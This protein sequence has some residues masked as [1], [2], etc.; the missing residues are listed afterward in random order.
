MIVFGCPITDY[1]VYERYAEPGIKL[2]AEPDTEVLGYPN[3]GSIFRAYNL[4]CKQAAELEN[5]EALVL[6]HQDVEIVDP[7][8][9]AKVRDVFRD[10]EV[11][12]AGCTGAVGVR[13]LAWW[14]GS[15]TWG[16]YN[17]V[18]DEIG[19]DLPGLSWP[20]E[21][22]FYARTGE[23]DSIDG[24]LIALSPWAVR[25]LRFDENLG[26]LHGYDL[27]ISLQARAAGKKV[28]AFDGRVVHHHGVD[29]I[30]DWEGWIAAHM[31]LAEKWS[32][33]LE[34]G[35]SQDW[36]ARARRAE[37]EVDA[38]WMQLRYAREHVRRLAADVDGFQESRSWRLTAPLRAIGKLLRRIRHPRTSPGRQLGEGLMK[39]RAELPRGDKPVETPHKA[40]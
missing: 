21:R 24:V 17:Q 11:A 6:I 36:R 37:A 19:A 13:S 18:F 40:A 29:L 10:P 23:V 16:S 38:A 35:R 3:P 9:C 30:G 39:P 33:L 14:E 8:L 34:D 5:L 27:D 31:T 7:E 25:E 2:A 28:V 12:V 20:A 32:D 26:R 22:P 4:F 15:T 1:D